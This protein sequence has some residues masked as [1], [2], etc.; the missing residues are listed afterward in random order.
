MEKTLRL[1]LGG[2]GGGLET[3]LAQPP[4]PSLHAQP[5]PHPPTWLL[6][7]RLLEACGRGWTAGPTRQH[8]RKRNSGAGGT[9]VGSQREA[10]AVGPPSTPQSPAG[11][12]SLTSATRIHF[13]RSRALWG[14]RSGR[15]VTSPGPSPVEVAPRT[16]LTTAPATLLNCVTVARTDGQRWACPGRSL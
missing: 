3:G 16:E 4:W 14:G 2:E 5:G 7:P 6:P 10:A 9:P 1:S 15:T 12:S 11:R 13:S 8:T